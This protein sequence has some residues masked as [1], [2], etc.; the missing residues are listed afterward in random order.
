[1]PPQLFILLIFLVVLIFAYRAIT[2]VMRNEPKEKLKEELQ[3]ALENQADFI[4]LSDS[5]KENANSDFAKKIKQG[6]ITSVKEVQ[7][8]IAEWTK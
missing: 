1:M 6:K 2:K 7:A 3:E 8:F 5:F 4:A